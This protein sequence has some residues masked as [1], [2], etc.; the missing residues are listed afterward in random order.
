MYDI[1]IL[2]DTES[3]GIKQERDFHSQ[4][5]IEIALQVRSREAVLETYHNFVSTVEEINQAVHPADHIE[6]FRNG[7]SGGVTLARIN[8]D[9][10]R[11]LAKYPQGKIVCHNV[12]FDLR[13]LR[14]NGIIIDEQRP[15]ICTMRTNCLPDGKYRKLV[16]LAKSL[17]VRTEDI[18][19]HTAVGDVELLS[20]C[21]TSILQMQCGT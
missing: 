20:R 12:N 2:I 11:I 15:T 7:I 21:L 18:K 6:Y 1:F 17:N 14:Y 19:L 4:K 8:E 5:L 13:L 9:L 10:A 3:D 16:D